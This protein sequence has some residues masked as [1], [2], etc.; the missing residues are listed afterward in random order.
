MDSDDSWSMCPVQ[1]RVQFPALAPNGM[2]HGGAGSWV[3]KVCGHNGAI[4][5]QVDAR[6]TRCT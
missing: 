6:Y 5:A 4:D 2:Q 1:S 3:V